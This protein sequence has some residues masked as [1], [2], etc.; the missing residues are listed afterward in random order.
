MCVARLIAGWVWECGSFDGFGLNCIYTYD[1]TYIYIYM[2][3]I[4]IN[5]FETVLDITVS[6]V[7]DHRL[8]S[9]QI[10]TVGPQQVTREGRAP[11]T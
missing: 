7:L 6:F 2:C 3:I 1:T 4:I 9:E 8:A 11:V 5:R 10:R